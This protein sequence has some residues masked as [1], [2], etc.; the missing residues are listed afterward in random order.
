MCMWDEVWEE[1]IIEQYDRGSRH[2]EDLEN[3][4]WAPPPLDP[5]VWE[6][7]AEREFAH[8]V[9]KYIAPGVKFEK[10]TNVRATVG[11]HQFGPFRPDMI[12]RRPGRVIGLEIDGR[13]YHMDRERDGLRDSALIAGRIVSAIYRFSASNSLFTPNDCLYMMSYYEP[14]LFSH[15]ARDHHLPRLASD[16]AKAAIF[17][18]E[19]AIAAES[20]EPDDEFLGDAEPRLE[21]RT[22]SL[23]RIAPDLEIVSRTATYIENSLNR[24]PGLTFSEMLAKYRPALARSGLS[25]QHAR[26]I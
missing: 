14:M 26:A 3:A 17:S 13:D 23:T 5:R 25:W 18:S 20:A 21:P 8:F 19:G 16:R 22:I 6:S 15:R 11:R 2:D 10:G 12:L 24:S 9:Y 7:Q 1:E 4:D